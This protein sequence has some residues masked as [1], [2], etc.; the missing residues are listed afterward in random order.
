MAN[1]V[2]DW[3]YCDSGATWPEWRG[4]KTKHHTYVKW[5]EGREELY[6]DLEDPYQM[7]NL[8]EGNKDQMT[9]K[10]LRSRLKDLLDNAHDTFPPGT[11]YADW[12]DNRRNIVRTALGKI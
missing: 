5:L 9:L 10:Q 6:D 8:A 1:Y 2:L 11:A 3:D 7:R 12:L 4:V